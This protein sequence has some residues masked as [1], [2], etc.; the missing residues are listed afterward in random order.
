MAL[1]QSD[2]LPEVEAV[3]GL[4]KRIWAFVLQ[5]PSETRGPFDHTVYEERLRLFH[6][7]VKWCLAQLECAPTTGKLHWQGVMSFVNEVRYGTL[8]ELWGSELGWCAVPKNKDAMITYC[9][10]DETRVVE[11]ER[12]RYGEVPEVKLS[13]RAKGNIRDAFTT[14]LAKRE[15]TLRE[16]LI[17][18]P[19]MMTNIRYWKSL[20]IE[21]DSPRT[22]MTQIV[23]IYGAPK[24]G[25]SKWFTY[26]AQSMGWRMMR[27][28]HSKEYKWFEGYDG[29]ELV[30]IDEFDPNEMSLVRL[31]YLADE[32]EA[33]VETKNGSVQFKA[34]ILGI[35][36]NMHPSLIYKN[37]PEQREALKRRILWIMKGNPNFMMTVENKEEMFPSPKLEL[38]AGAGTERNN[39]SSV[40]EA[41]KIE[42]IVGTS[43]FPLGYARE[44]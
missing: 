29:Q 21:T 38:G 22:E 39:I 20:L 15:I 3:A 40:P 34:K 32:H 28:L 1:I 35:T 6:V 13:K 17:E 25:K 11:F 27:L 36:T 31:N 7:E 26:Y 33:K 10:K 24:T 9:Q 4:K 23:L 44:L 43:V 14:K 18:D 42:S 8:H 19:T 41:P 5:V 30:V 12:I 2:N 16:V 37:K